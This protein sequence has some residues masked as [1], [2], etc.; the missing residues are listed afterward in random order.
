MRAF[1]FS[2]RSASSLV[3]V[4]ILLWPLALFPAETGAPAGP[5]VPDGT[6]A[7]IK[8][9]EAVY[10]TSCQ[11]CHSLKYSGYEAK[12]PA[13]AALKAFGKVPPDLNL[14]TAARG[15]GR[16]GA[17]YIASLLLGFNDTPEKNSVFPN[18]AMPPAFSRND[19][20]AGR[21]ARDVSIF[22]ADAAEP[23]GRESR[24]LGRYVLGYMVLLTALFYT[25]NR[26]TWKG[27]DHHRPSPSE[28]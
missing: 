2:P 14:M 24:S 3:A 25:L 28:R 27:I 13:A 22:L 5:P 12:M 15:G 11:A 7:S 26:R 19:P 9:G 6:D 4:L 20:E 17:E 18:I 23:S 16:T 10:R 8:R 1:R 21:K